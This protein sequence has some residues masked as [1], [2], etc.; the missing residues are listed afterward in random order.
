MN[1]PDTYRAFFTHRGATSAAAWSVVGRI[2]LYLTSLAIVLVGID[3][4]NSL[5]DTGL[6]LAAYSIGG[7]VAA[8]LVAR[9]MDRRGQTLPL[10]V[11]AF[12]HFAAIWALVLL[13]PSRVLALVVVAVG[14]ATIP[15]VTP[16]IR[17]LWSSLPLGEDGRRG[18]YATEA[19]LGEIFVILGPIG[20]SLALVLADA[21]VALLV[22]SSM[23]ALGAVGLAATSASRGWE[24]QRLRDGRLSGSL[25]SRSFFLLVGVLLLTAAA[26]G[27]Y[28]LL[29]PA[30]AAEDGH[31]AAAGLLFGV[32]GIGS[33][34]GGLWFGT[35]K[36]SHRSPATLFSVGIFVVTVGLVLPLF[37][38]DSL[39]MAVALIVGGLAIAPVSVVEYD[40][41]QRL[42][43]KA[44]ISEA[45]TWIM[46]ATVAGGAVGAQIA[47]VAAQE[48]GVQGGFAIA[49]VLGLAATALALAS[50]STWVNALSQLELKEKE[51]AWP[52]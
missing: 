47:G 17:A 9:W 41:I 48:W 38:T 4:G 18:A 44:H 31:K 35:R 33:A 20:L 1:V 45:F 21:K 10:I 3:S 12:I 52:A 39:S 29:V 50:H 19:V 13:E 26:T 42:A 49:V 23:T 37:A 30:F 7:A 25:W 6:M 2:P 11:T 34:V 24:P 51:K 28:T 40:L 36:A 15:P 16:S 46:T 5:I 32:W 8:P 27:T 43:P 14:G 22:A